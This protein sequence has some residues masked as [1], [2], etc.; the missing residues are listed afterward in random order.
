MNDL[1][2]ARN[3]AREEGGNWQKYQNK[4]NEAYG[5]KKRHEGSADETEK[6][7]GGGTK[8]TTTV[9]KE[10]VTTKTSKSGDR[11][12]T[13]TEN[14][15]GKGKTVTKG[16]EVK[17]DKFKEGKGKTA[18]GAETGNK[19]TKSGATGEAADQDYYSKKAA[20]GGKGSRIAKRIAKREAKGKPSGEGSRTDKLK[21]K[22][23][24]KQGTK[25]TKRNRA[26][27]A[28]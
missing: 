6:T 19:E 20:E 10:T 26:E 23:W 8:S 16:G 3:K 28:W 13:T 2:A 24:D 22:Y 18:K 5:V 27:K 11:V 7:L 1:V 14:L 25:I 17:K 21:G 4:I 15:E 12:K 9:G